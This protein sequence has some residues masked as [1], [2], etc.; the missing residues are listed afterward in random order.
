MIF[1]LLLIVINGHST[2][3][4]GYTF[5]T[6]AECQ[7]VVEYIDNTMPYVDIKVNCLEMREL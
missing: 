2:I 6:L 5:N 4:E 1:Y 7:E 3:T